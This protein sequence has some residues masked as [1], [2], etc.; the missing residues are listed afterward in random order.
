M[1][2]GAGQRDRLVLVRGQRGVGF[3]GMARVGSAFVSLLG[4]TE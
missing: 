4:Y 2:K 1:K 3:F